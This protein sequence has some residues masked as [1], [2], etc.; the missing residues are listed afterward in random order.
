[1]ISPKESVRKMYDD[2]A[3][4]YSKMM[5]GEIDLPFYSDIF[6]QI[7]AC[8]ANLSGPIIDTSCG[9]GHMLYH[10]HTNYESERP[11]LGVDLSPEMV[12]IA[13]EK[14]GSAA[15]IY[16]GDMRHLNREDFPPAASIL[17]FFALHHL[18]SD[19]I[20]ATLRLWSSLLQSGGW[21][22]LATW[23]GH[24]PIDYGESADIIAMR[25]SCEQI[26]TWAS[27]NGF[28]V[29]REAVVPVEGLPM[30]AVLL[31]ANKSE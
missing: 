23:E 17:S 21:L 7:Q 12:K 31:S 9:S 25:Y 28:T 19:D 27:Q 5:D 26:S 24:G 14:L 20:P 10:Y 13:E 11:L 2:T 29:D 18:S 3:A 4:S 1:M 6:T 22:F 30:D 8:I 16:E 15:N